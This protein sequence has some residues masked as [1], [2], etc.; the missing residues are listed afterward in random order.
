MS[1]KDQALFY[2]LWGSQEAKK[3]MMASSP[4]NTIISYG[5]AIRSRQQARS[6][7]ATLEAQ[8]IV[9]AVYAESLLKSRLPNCIIVPVAE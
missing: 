6:G 4:H 7:A 1:T 2:E 8:D 9:A 5:E 3:R